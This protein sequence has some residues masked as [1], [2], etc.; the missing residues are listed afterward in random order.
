MASI[1][2]ASGDRRGDC[3]P[4]GRRTNVIGRAESVPIQV[5][6]DRIS[7]KHAQIRFESTTNRYWIVDMASRNGVFVNGVRIEGQA[8]LT[9]RDSVRIGDTLL[10]FTENQNINSTVAL[11]RFKKAGERD[12]RTHV[13]LNSRR[14]V[15]RIPVAI[16][17][18]RGGALVA[19]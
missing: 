2:I 19:L 5:L 3:Y 12:R 8:A 1:V 17:R 18:E 9:D 6:D 14:C 4:L 7:R 15:G 16:G 11:H 13:D 10:L